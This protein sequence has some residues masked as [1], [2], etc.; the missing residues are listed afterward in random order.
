MTT[1]VQGIPIVVIGFIARGVAEF[2]KWEE[3]WTNE[4]CED[5]WRVPTKAGNDNVS[6]FFLK[7][8]Q[9]SMRWIN[10]RTW[11]RMS[12]DI[13]GDWLGDIAIPGKSS[14][15]Q[16]Q[17]KGDFAPTSTFEQEDRIRISEIDYELGHHSRKK[18]SE[19]GQEIIVVKAG[20]EANQNSQKNPFAV[21]WTDQTKLVAGRKQKQGSYQRVYQRLRLPILSRGRSKMGAQVYGERNAGIT[22]DCLGLSIVI[23]PTQN[24]DWI[25]LQFLRN[26]VKWR[27]QISSSCFEF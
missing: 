4:K 8:T 5:D 19:P 25:S 22:I 27:K 1:F 13:R 12:F 17:R 16:D 11:I 2:G 3:F 26:R 23:Q 21:P 24:Q 18:A 14:R 15:T 9:P 20:E 6:L 10:V 7:W